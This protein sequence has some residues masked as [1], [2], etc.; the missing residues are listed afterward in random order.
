[1]IYTLAT[2]LLAG[3]APRVQGAN[4]Q[5][6]REQG[7]TKINLW[8]MKNYFGEHQEKNSGSREKRVKVR[9]EPGAE[10]PPYRVSLLGGALQAT[11]LHGNILLQVQ[12]THCIFSL[13]LDLQQDTSKVVPPSKN[14]CHPP[15]K[16]WCTANTALG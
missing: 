7:D 12:H 11:P 13:Q 3:A 16:L 4:S 2:A 9:R 14:P 10:V 6:P 15:L 8:S 5:M 1:M